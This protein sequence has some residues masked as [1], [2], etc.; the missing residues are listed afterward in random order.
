MLDPKFQYLPYIASEQKDVYETDDADPSPSEYYEEELE[1]ES[2]DKSKLNTSD[3]YNKFKGKYLI[4]NV[5][6]S[7]NIGKR[8][9]I[10][11]N[12]V[13]GVWE[14]A[15]E[16]EKENP[17]QKCQRLQ[18]E[19]SEL[20]DEI[21]SLQND[22]TVS[23][24]ERESY[25]GVSKVVLTAKKVLDSLRLEQ[26]LGK[27]AVASSSEKQVKNLITQVEEYKKGVPA[28]AAE[29]LKL[30]S[31]NELSYTT[32]IAELEHK[33][34]QIEQTVGASKTD[35]ISRL[36][37][38]L[39]TK[40][41]LEAV[42]QLSTKSALLQPNQ[43]DVIEQRLTNLASK[44]DQFNDKA[45]SSGTDPA[46]DQKISE[47]YD[48]AKSTEPITKVLPDMLER[49]KTLEALHSYA[50]NFSK[51]FAEL[52]ETQANILKGIANNKELLQGVTKA[53]VENN[54]NVSKEIQKL[55]TRVNQVTGKK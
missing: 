23:K 46:R 3:A 20:M 29:L 16:G 21:T 11:Y 40:N 34:H 1:S 7:D 5:D 10:G 30:N 42:Q 51:L 9:N 17:I 36:N 32:R 38:S 53:F 44:M 12:A 55:E 33:L 49:M 54:E 47:L 18:C 6:F 35:K 25:D 50:A 27:E 8:K 31:Q 19:M 28:T 37:S 26:V 22:N 52:E 41:L 15:G 13:S 43:L 45:A 48:L 4:G 24:E 2:I 14:L 39:G